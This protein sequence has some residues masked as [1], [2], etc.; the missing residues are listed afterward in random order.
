MRDVL[1]ARLARLARLADELRAHGADGD[2]FAEYAPGIL[3]DLAA[4]AEDGPTASALADAVARLGAA[5][6]EIWTPLRFCARPLAGIC[7][8]DAAAY[9]AALTTLVD[10]ALALAGRDSL[11]LQQGL[12]AALDAPGCDARV[13]LA[14]LRL[15]RDWA[16]L[17]IEP[18]SLL[19]LAVPAAIAPGDRLDARLSALADAVAA[20]DA[21]GVEM[22]E[23]VVAALAGALAAWPDDDAGAATALAALVG[24]AAIARAAGHEVHVVFGGV[25]VAL[26]AAGSRPWL[27]DEV[28]AL[29]RLMLLRGVAPGALLA[30]GWPQIAALDEH[31]ARAVIA[32]AQVDAAGGG[33][34]GPF[35]AEAA[36]DLAGASDDP[37][38]RGRLFAAAASALAAARASGQPAR[39]VWSG[40]APVIA[41]AL[42]AGPAVGVAA[43]DTVTAM[44][45]AGIDAGPACENGLAVALASAED[46]PGRFA[47]LIALATAL[48]EAGVSPLYPLR[49]AARA[50]VAIADDDAA[51]ATL[52]AAVLG[53]ARALAARGF[54]AE[55]MLG[56]AFFD[57]AR[58]LGVDAVVALL[59]R[60]DELAAAMADTSDGTRSAG[61]ALSAALAAARGAPWGL[62]AVGDL[63][64]RCA[65]LGAAPTL[66]VQRAGPA[67]FAL[68]GGDR[69]A[70]AAAVDGLI[71]AIG[72][73]RRR[74][75]DAVGGI[76]DSLA[77][78]VAA[79]GDQRRSGLANATMALAQRLSARGAPVPGGL[80]DVVAALADPADALDA[81]LAVIERALGAADAAALGSALGDHVSALVVLAGA[82]VTL[83]A[84][85]IAALSGALR[86]L[87]DGGI[88]AATARD[89]LG[90]ALRAMSAG[91]AALRLLPALAELIAVNGGSDRALVRQAAAVAARVCA[92]DGD[93]LLA[94]AAHVLRRT[95][96]GAP[97]ELIA[98]VMAHAGLVGDAAGARGVVDDIA[99]LL[100]NPV[101]VERVGECVALFDALKPLTR[102]APAAWRETIV[103]IVVSQ[104]PAAPEALLE[105]T[106]LG[107]HARDRRAQALIKRFATQ[108][109]VRCVDLM[110]GVLVAG[111]RDG[112]I[113]DL[114]AE[115]A[116]LVEFVRGAP[117]ADARAYAA[118][119]AI[120]ADP[121]LTSVERRAAIDRLGSD[122][123]R[124][125]QAVRAGEPTRADEAHPLFAQV[126]YHVFP[127]AAG[128]GRDAYRA[129]YDGF[130]DHPA[131]LDRFA[132]PGAP[133]AAD[134][135]LAAGGYRVR[136][137]ERLDPAPWAAV[138]AAA[139]AIAAQPAEDDAALGRDLFAA[140][141]EG[142]I[143][144]E[145]DRGALIA[146]VLAAHRRARGP[147]PDDLDS[148]LGMIACRDAL[149]DGGRDVVRDALA[150]HRAQDPER[151][152]RRARVR[153]APRSAI[154]PGLARAVRLTVAAARTG[155][156]P[157]D[158]A[159]ARLGRQLAGFADQ[160]EVARFVDLDEAAVDARLAG[161]ARDDATV[162]LGD[163]HLRVLGDLVGAD[164][165]AMQR[166]LFGDNDRRGKL[167]H[168]LGGGATR[169]LRLAATKR[170]AH[171]AV[172][173]CEGVCTAR[174]RGLWDDPEFLQVVAW[175]EVGRAQGG[176]HLYALRG[177]HGDALVAPGINPSLR[178]LGEVGAAA[179]LGAALD[180][181]RRCA[182][183]WGF[184]HAWVPTATYIASNRAAVYDALAG[185]GL[186]RRAIPGARFTAYDYAE[187]WEIPA[188]GA[189]ALP[190]GCAALE[191]RSSKLE[192]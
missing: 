30:H 39:R 96:S 115:A 63:A 95:P 51:F 89:V 176:M 167:E 141:I 189:A 150:A 79:A 135:A 87:S 104:G 22:Y 32:V 40:A 49:Y 59:G 178:L 188:R 93:A 97:A 131:H 157:R 5:G 24:L 164:I 192:A 106:R 60:L 26:D 130:T 27:R 58:G 190:P 72:A 111:I 74:D 165:A 88:D 147:L 64:R 7:A 68:A 71:A 183:A 121:T 160:D 116:D 6:V 28:I 46:A 62:E 112:A 41:R 50:A 15:G 85:L 140:W 182:D 173:F 177:A 123:A 101:V 54:P 69:H 139:A 148:V 92:G 55:D 3:A 90:P 186:K 94:L 20:L 105:L 91:A 86:R 44:L 163:E 149:A 184:A 82:D 113:A 174:D 119:R 158:E 57:L 146:R 67:L 120:H 9:R 144:R 152:D 170:R 103:P 168:R 114:G 42:M 80:G 161:L 18:R 138:R 35:L 45:R 4:P 75:R 154:G 56:A 98:A 166:E 66:V 102:A 162:I 77:Q 8:G 37:G 11:A 118:W 83:F 36:R 47:P 134:Y 84:R 128:V 180:F 185:L 2:R 81:R 127:P 181:A 142:R 43:L 10:L 117:F 65:A 99:R 153:L 109:G 179:F 13:A 169:R 124:L 17:G 159:L 52:L 143:G 191:A 16:R 70:F 125:A 23:A 38:H 126:L 155:E 78:A 175:D 76:A 187:V 129:L 108:E 100:G 61:Y 53:A 12:P 145:P 171:A 110:A 19:R 1:L 136:D 25:G 31:G 172:G 21:L 48:A 137:G 33:D 14:A 34:P 73:L 132:P 122:L 151:Y 29:A 133:R 156:V 107:E